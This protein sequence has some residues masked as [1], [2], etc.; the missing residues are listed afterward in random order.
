MNQFTGELIG[1]ERME[2]I[3]EDLES[4]IRDYAADTKR[5]SE[6]AEL[7]LITAREGKWIGG[8]VKSIIAFMKTLTSPDFSTEHK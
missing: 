4:G 1:I 6:I 7:T 5:I 8:E 3:S 2:S